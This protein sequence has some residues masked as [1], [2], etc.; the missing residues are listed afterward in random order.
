MAESSS[1]STL[2]NV[3]SAADRGLL[4]EQYEF[5][6]SQTNDDDKKPSTW[7]DRMVQRYN[8]GLYREYALADLSCPGQLGL[9]W[10]TRQEVVDGRGEKSCGNKRC[11]H[12][13]GLVTMEVPFAYQEGGIKKK[14]LV[15][16]RLCPTCFPQVRTKGSDKAS[17]KGDDG[18]S[19][20]GV[21]SSASEDSSRE[22]RKSRKRKKKT[23]HHRKKRRKST[24]SPH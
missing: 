13:V 1:K 3:V 8:D 15:K 21:S 7:Q 20:S 12:S 5:V 9:R 2:K 17:D 10:R 16:L 18:S 6:P 19:H 23:K 22:R 11:L 14:E 24:E 4:E